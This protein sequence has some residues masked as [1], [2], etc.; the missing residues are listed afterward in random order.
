MYI[1]ILCVCSQ[2]LYT[3]L[4]EF[5]YAI[6]PTPKGVGFSHFSISNKVTIKATPNIMHTTPNTDILN[7]PF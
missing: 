3:H 4:I 1:I 2:A 6:H 5:Y 7:P